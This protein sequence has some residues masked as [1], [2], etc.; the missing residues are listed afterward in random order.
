[1]R[2]QPALPLV[3]TILFLASLDISAQEG[4]AFLGFSVAAEARQG[5]PLPVSFS[6]TLP[7]SEGSIR[8]VDAKGRSVA[9]GR[10]FLVSWNLGRSTWLALPGIPSDAVA[11]PARLRVTALTPVG[12]VS[13]ERDV[14]ILVRDFPTEDIA[15]NPVNTTIRSVPDARK[16]TQAISI[17]DIYARIDPAALYAN[18][19]FVLPVERVRRSAGY[20]DRRRYLYA[21]GG[22]DSSQHSGIDFAVPADTPVRS[23]A[24]GR[25]VFAEL[26]I[27]TGNT[28]VIEHLPGLYS[29]LMH[30]SALEVTEGMTVDAGQELARSGSTGLST[31]PHLHWEV[32]A[33]GVAVDP[34]WFVLH[35][36]G[37]R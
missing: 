5:D 22:I 23:P 29:V 33:G 1:M 3:L 10:P 18:A 9:R 14:L 35:E 37:L 20:G 21:G 8:I 34:D 6:S 30:L 26:R 2:Y 31:G 32:R 19:A 12:E 24:A 28:L 4:G 7:L 13:L 17:Q 11:G 25:V 16:T 36:L 27:V 15:L